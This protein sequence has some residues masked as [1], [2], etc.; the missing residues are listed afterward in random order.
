LAGK[1][2]VGIQTDSGAAVDVHSLQH[3]PVV[4]VKWS[5]LES[6]KVAKGSNPLNRSIEHTTEQLGQTTKKDF[7]LYMLQVEK[8]PVGPTVGRTID[9]LNALGAWRSG[10]RIRVR[11]RRYGFESRQGVRFF[12]GKHCSAVMSMDL[13]CIVCVTFTD[14]TRHWP[15]NIFKKHRIEYIKCKCRDPKELI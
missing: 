1:K 3:L 10:H 7:A 4:T 9:K 13:I 12:K 6:L 5:K 11:H 2:W 14:K 15:K 8:N